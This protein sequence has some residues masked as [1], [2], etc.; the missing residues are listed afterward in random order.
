MCQLI[1]GETKKEE[2]DWGNWGYIKPEKKIFLRNN[3]QI[4]SKFN[5]NTQIQGA[6]QNPSSVNVFKITLCGYNIVTLLNTK[7]TKSKS[8]Q[9]KRH[10]K[11]RATMKRTKG[12]FS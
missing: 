6:Q 3:N 12:D 11:F 9:R 4:Y 8:S 5:I 10:I 7:S 2:R 1:K